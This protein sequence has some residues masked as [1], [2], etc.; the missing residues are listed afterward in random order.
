MRSGKWRGMTLGL[1][2]AL[3]LILAAGEARTARAQFHTIPRLVPAVDVNSGGPYYA[4]PVPGGHYTGKNLHGK[5][6]GKVGGLLHGGIP[7]AGLLHHGGGKGCGPCG[8]CGGK[9]CGTCGGTGDA[10]GGTGNETGHGHGHGGMI[11]GGGGCG[12]GHGSGLCPSGVCASS[13][14]TSPIVTMSSSQCGNAG[15]GLFG[16]HRHQGCGACG[17]KG[18]GGCAVADPCNACGGKGCGL[19]GGGGHGG[20][21]GLCKLCGGIGCGACAKAKGLVS[22]LL[23]HDKIKW[24]NGPGGPV[25]LTPGYVPYINVTRSPRDFLSFPPFAP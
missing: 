21:G 11:G 23:G 1:G 16:K 20:L 9:G 2:L 22:H 12:V 6:A 4:P 5:L 10:C 19:C 8:S 15:C 3:G 14:G 24:F 13:Q 17:G 18:C 25:P 7:G